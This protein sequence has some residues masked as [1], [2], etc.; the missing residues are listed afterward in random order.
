MSGTSK[1]VVSMCVL[2][3]AALVVYYGMTPPEESQGQRIDLPKQRPSLFGGDLEKKMIALGIPPVATELATLQ[4][5]EPLQQPNAVFPVA[6][7]VRPEPIVVEVEPTVIEPTE[8]QIV[9][10]TYKTYT[11]KEGE[12]LGEIASRELGSYRKWREIA[13]LNDISDPSRVM[14]GRMLRLPTMAAA[15]PVLVEEPAEVVPANIKIHT[16]QEGETMS[17]IAG[18]YYD[19]V[20]KYSAI[21]NANP[22][23]DPSR[24]K[25]GSTIIIPAL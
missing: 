10:Q 3:L 20:N 2:L 17:S 11:V 6:P 22:S 13:T 15:K 16:I 4:A 1:A 14:P 9:E 18:D 8:V 12:T 5:A 21:V 25:I 24:L 7:T 19:D 23:V